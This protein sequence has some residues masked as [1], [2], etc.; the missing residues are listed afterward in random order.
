VFGPAASDVRFCFCLPYVGADL[1]RFLK[2]YAGRRELRA[3]VLCR[4]RKGRSVELLRLGSLTRQPQHRLL[5]TCRHHAC[6]T[7]A[8]YVLEGLI[9]AVLADDQEGRWLREQAE[10]FIVPFVDKDGVEEGDQGKLR[11]PHDHWLDYAGRSIYPEVRAIRKRVAAWYAGRMH[12]ALD[13]HCPY[14]TDRHIYLAGS[15]DPRIAAALQR[16]SRLLASFATGPLR[17]DPRHNMPFGKGWNTPRTYGQHKSMALWAE[18]FPEMRLAATLEVPYA[19]VESE[20]VTPQSA[21]RFGRDL[22]RALYAFLRGTGAGAARANHRRPGP[23][24]KA[25]GTASRKHPP[26]L[27]EKPPKGTRQSK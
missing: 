2:R 25:A 13:I 15:A 8:N 7:T 6:E 17:Y 10:F 9:A 23:T 3:E 16:F 11:R 18:Q 14:M 24:A 26:G 1:Q 4:S 27:P 20:P 21:R 5:I 19:Q 12:V 22:A